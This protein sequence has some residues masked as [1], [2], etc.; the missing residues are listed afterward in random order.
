MTL[1]AQ[2]MALPVRFYRLVFSPWVGH[3]C[4]YQPTCSAYAM[5]ALEKHGGFKG[6][7]LAARRVFRCHPWGGSGVDNVPD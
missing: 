6:T 7:W 1:F 2:V 4:R 5:E 3:G